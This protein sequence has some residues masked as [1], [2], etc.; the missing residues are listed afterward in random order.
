MAMIAARHVPFAALVLLAACR[1]E[2]DPVPLYDGEWI[3]VGG[4]GR[5]R[6]DTCIGTFDYV[7]AYAGALAAEFGIDGPIGSYVW[8]TPEDFDA[9]LPCSHPYPSA[10]AV[11]NVAHSAR[12]PHE[13]EMV[14]V[15][16]HHS[17]LGPNI[18]TEGIAIYYSTARVTGDDL[19]IDALARRLASPSDDVPSGDYEMLGRFAGFLIERHGL[20]AVL[21]V[22]AMAGREATG[23]Q[24]SAA[25]QSI[26]GA[27]PDELLT[28]LS[29]E[30][31]YCNDI[32]RYRSNVFA[33]GVAAAAPSLGSFVDGHLEARLD[34]G[35][36]EADVVG[37]FVV[38]P[39]HGK[40]L[41]TLS[42]DLPIDEHYWF[43]V[44]DETQ[45]DQPIPEGITFVAS[46]CAPCGDWARNSTEVDWPFP[47]LG[48]F[49]AGR[50]SVEI[51]MPE[52]Y[53]GT[54]R[55]EVDFY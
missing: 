1:G 49:R 20:Q 35:C 40:L 41:R 14:H 50:Y 16:H 34:F 4:I 13:H 39:N 17:G 28:A 10:C 30:P 23:A 42:L 25:M 8:Y 51:A 3:D 9:L 32:D 18:L 44:Y 11:D 55:L 12:L 53:V 48:D 29:Q 27:S 38:G 31:G 19:N 43:N 5:E 7:D 21:E 37:P 6:S 46:Q 2:V 33:C 54:V 26:L 36:D 47:L 22:C 24:L 52:D 45:E 15:A